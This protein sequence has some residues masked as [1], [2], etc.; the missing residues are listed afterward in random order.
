MARTDPTENFERGAIA[1]SDRNQGSRIA[2]GER[3]SR[4]PRKSQLGL[5]HLFTFACENIPIAAAM[6]WLAKARLGGD[7]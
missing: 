6:S 4:E 1:E 5:K 2:R 3:F 7:T